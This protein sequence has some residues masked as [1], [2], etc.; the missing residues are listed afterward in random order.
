MPARHSRIAG[1]HEH[2]KIW[3]NKHVPQTFHGIDMKRRVL[4]HERVER[5]LRLRKKNPLP[6]R[7]AHKIAL[8]EEHR[9]LSKKQVFQYE[10]KLG[11]IARDHPRII[12]NG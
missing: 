5:K 10:G 7:K 4:R 9:G 8:E 12:H 2:G 11:Q 1:Y 3:V 6:Y